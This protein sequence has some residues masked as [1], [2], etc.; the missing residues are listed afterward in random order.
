MPITYKHT[1]G[2]KVV[3][4]NRD[5]FVKFGDQSFGP[6]APYDTHYTALALL[7]TGDLTLRAVAYDWATLNDTGKSVHNWTWRGGRR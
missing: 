1:T 4:N 7:A 6:F 2:A 3:V 5:Q